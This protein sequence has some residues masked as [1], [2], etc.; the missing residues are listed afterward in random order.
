MSS[1]I[2]YLPN[3]WMS[4]WANTY[5]RGGSSGPD[6]HMAEPTPSIPPGDLPPPADTRPGAVPPPGLSHRSGVVVL[7]LALGA[8]GIATALAPWLAPRLED[9]A[10]TVEG[11]LGVELVPQEMDR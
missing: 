2:W 5:T 3:V 11:A 4:D 8:W 6:P 7:A 10:D 1:R 9:L